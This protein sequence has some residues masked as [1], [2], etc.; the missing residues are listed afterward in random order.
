MNY[1]FTGFYQFISKQTKQSTVTIA[2]LLSKL[3]ILQLSLFLD[4]FV[5]KVDRG[6]TERIDEVN[7]KLVASVSAREDCESPH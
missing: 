7:M 3:T 1:T 5:L 4:L 6:F 2:I